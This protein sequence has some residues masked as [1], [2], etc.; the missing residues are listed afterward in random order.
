MLNLMSSDDPIPPSFRRAFQRAMSKSKRAWEKAGYAPTEDAAAP[1]TLYRVPD[2]LARA[3]GIPLTGK[4]CVLRRD[5]DDVVLTPFSID[6]EPGISEILI[7]PE[8]SPYGDGARGG[9]VLHLWAQL[10]LPQASLSKLQVGA[11]C[12]AV[13]EIAGGLAVLAPPPGAQARYDAWASLARSLR[14]GR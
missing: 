4:L 9:L 14:D 5:G 3:H 2:D 8:Q 13:A 11:R 12:P 10:R 7:P 6:G 1:G